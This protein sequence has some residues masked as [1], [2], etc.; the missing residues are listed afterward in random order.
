MIYFLVSVFK[1]TN[2]VRYGRPLPTISISEEAIVPRD[3]SIEKA[4]TV[5]SASVASDGDHDSDFVDE[6]QVVAGEATYV[7]ISQSLAEASAVSSA[8][9]TCDGHPD[10]DSDD[11]EEVEAGVICTLTSD[12]DQDSDSDDDEEVEAGKAT[13][14]PMSQALEVA[15]T[16]SSAT[17]TSDGYQGS[18]SYEDKDV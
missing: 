10:S 18:N 3:P 15:S 17:K 2:L 9:I 4:P 8:P 14:V 7:S 5:S 12:G 11:E 13:D 1:E 6:E 16:V